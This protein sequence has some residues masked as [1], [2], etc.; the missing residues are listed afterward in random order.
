MFYSCYSIS[1]AALNAYTVLIAN[2]LSA[3]NIKVNCVEPGYTATDMTD[4]QG[5]QTAEEAAKVIVKFATIDDDG[6]HGGYFDILGRL[7]W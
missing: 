5:F 7:P 3:N 4:H 2:E 1:K 6:P